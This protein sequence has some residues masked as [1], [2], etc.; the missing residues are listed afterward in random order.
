MEGKEVVRAE[1]DAYALDNLNSYLHSDPLSYWHMQQDQWQSLSAVALSKVPCK[2]PISVY[3]KRAFSTA[4]TIVT[5]QRTWLTSKNVIMLCFICVE[6]S[7]AKKDFAIKTS[8][9]DMHK[10]AKNSK[11]KTCS[12][13]SFIYWWLNI[14][15]KHEDNVCTFSNIQS[16]TVLLFLI[17]PLKDNV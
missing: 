10:N 8:V 17:F 12:S 9:S 5:G 7:L 6:R 14:S 15:L 2:P 4:G 13:A 1:L 11:N 3:C 16:F